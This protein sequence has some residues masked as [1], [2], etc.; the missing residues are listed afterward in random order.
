MSGPIP[1]SGPF[2]FFV[3]AEGFA[4]QATIELMP[5]H[6]EVEHLLFGETDTAWMSACETALAQATDEISGLM[7]SDQER[8]MVTYLAVTDNTH[9][10]QRIGYLVGARA[11]AD[12]R[13]R[14]EWSEMARWPA[15]RGVSELT[16]VLR[17]RRSC[18]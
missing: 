17:S 8:H 2:G 10:P 11:V 3:F 18:T 12:L 7:S 6:T 5:E 1:E 15:E 14:Y 16:E 4:T 9:V 13:R